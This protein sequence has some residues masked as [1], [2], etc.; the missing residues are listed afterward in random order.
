MP[1]YL[2]Y[3]YHKVQVIIIYVLLNTIA[4]TLFAG[5]TQFRLPS[6]FLAFLSAVAIS[7]CSDSNDSQSESTNLYAL[8]GMAP[9]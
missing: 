1:K 6:I 4:T 9:V 5:H 8:E 3:N 2:S 7:G